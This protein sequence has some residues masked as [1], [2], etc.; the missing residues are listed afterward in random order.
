[1]SFAKLVR[2]FKEGF[3][4]PSGSDEPRHQPLQLATAAVLLEIAYA[5]GEF[6]PAE[7]G[8]VVGYLERAFALNSEGARELLRAADEIRTRTI[9]HFALTN[10][11]RQNTSQADRIEIVRTMW[12]IVFADGRLTD[13]ENYL[14]RKLADLLGIE[15]HVMIDVKVSV[16]AERGEA[17]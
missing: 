16:L 4:T 12:R 2:R 8:D 10:Y 9:D 14:V 11:I 6:Q 1:M 15:H 7:D 3:G 13:Y 17:S 5:D